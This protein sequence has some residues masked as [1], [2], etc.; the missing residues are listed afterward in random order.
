M[1]QDKEE[2]LLMKRFSFRRNPNSELD[3]ANLLNQHAPQLA[4]HGDGTQA[5]Y[6]LIDA[7]KK[8]YPN[9]P[10][11][12]IGAARSKAAALLAEH[13][14]RQSKALRASGVEESVLAIDTPLGELA[15][16]IR[17]KELEKAKENAQ[18]D[19]RE[20]EREGAEKLLASL[21]AGLHAKKKAEKRERTAQI[22]ENEKDSFDVYVKMRQE[23]YAKEEE[24]KAQKDVEEAEEKRRRLELDSEDI[25]LRKRRLELEE[26]S[27]YV[28]LCKLNKGHLMPKYHAMQNQ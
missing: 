6:D 5:W 3:F 20:E 16:K 11:L 10:A 26:L 13:N 12:S 27:T 18:N 2:Q 1:Q 4:K 14:S 8:K 24:Y 19:L 23:K 21:T 9:S 15:S 17:D 25:S 22:Q 28:E 7:L